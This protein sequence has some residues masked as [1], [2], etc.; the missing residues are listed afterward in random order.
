M[1]YRDLVAQWDRKHGE[2]YTLSSLLPPV[3]PTRAVAAPVFDPVARA[4]AEIRALGVA[5]VCDPRD[6]TDPGGTP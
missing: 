6:A 1:S 2:A 3:M 4:Y 5:L